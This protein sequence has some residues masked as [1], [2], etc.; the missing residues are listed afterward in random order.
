M[1]REMPSYRLEGSKASSQRLKVFLTLC[2]V[3]V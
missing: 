3:C 2:E 1:N